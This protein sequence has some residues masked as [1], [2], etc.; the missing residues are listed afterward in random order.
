MKKEPSNDE[1]LRAMR[2][3]AKRNSHVVPRLL[4]QQVRLLAD[5]PHFPNICVQV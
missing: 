1:A 5:F 3:K 4:K 2:K